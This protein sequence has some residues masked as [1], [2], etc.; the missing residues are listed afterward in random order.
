MMKTEYQNKVILNLKRLRE[1]NEFSQ[2]KVALFLGI[3]NGQIGNI[4]TPTSPHKYTLAQIAKLCK[5]FKVPIELVFYGNGV[6]ASK[7][8]KE[9]LLKKIIEYQ[10]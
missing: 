5:K 2:S 9:E 8:S 10:N 6:D 4:E 1:I 3:S 7:I